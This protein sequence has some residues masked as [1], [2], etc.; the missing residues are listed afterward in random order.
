MNKTH[1]KKILLAI[2]ADLLQHVNLYMGFAWVSRSEAIRTILRKHFD[3]F[4]KPLT[5]YYEEKMMIKSLKEN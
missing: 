1:T 2:P 4:G 5:A 3:H